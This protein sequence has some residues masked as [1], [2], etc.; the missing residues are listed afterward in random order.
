MLYINILFFIFNKILKIIIFTN[1][2]AATLK[3][4]YS[5]T[6]SNAK[7]FKQFLLANM[8]NKIFDAVFK[9]VARNHHKILTIGSKCGPRAKIGSRIL[10][11]CYKVL[12]CEMLT[13]MNKLFIGQFNKLKNR[14]LYGHGLKIYIKIMKIEFSFSFKNRKFRNQQIIF[15]IV[16]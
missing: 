13:L 6:T 8:K 15:K 16:I 12:Q 9:A 11:S 7:A 2:G 14:P 4:S 1:E 5:E 10:K 3:S